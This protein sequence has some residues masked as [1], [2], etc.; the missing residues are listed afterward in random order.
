MHSREE[1][2][3]ARDRGLQPKKQHGVAFDAWN[4][5]YLSNSDGEFEAH[6]HCSAET[7]KMPSNPAERQATSERG[8][9]PLPNMVSDYRLLPPAR[10][11]ADGLAIT[12]ALAL[13]SA[14]L[15]SKWSSLF[16]ACSSIWCSWNGCPVTGMESRV[17]AV[18]V[19]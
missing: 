18:P 17:M 8:S 6:S 3:A 16:A 12:A 15:A 9:G 19:G 5:V 10:R 1:P 7:E 11:R 4:H 13:P 14:M 2:A